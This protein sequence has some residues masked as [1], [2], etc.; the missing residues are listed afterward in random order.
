MKRPCRVPMI[1][2]P[3]AGRKKRFVAVG[4]GG[5]IPMFIDPIARDYAGD[6]ELV[7]LCDLSMVRMKYHQ[8]RL[9]RLYGCGQVR[10][11]RPEQFD[12]MLEELAP[13]SVIVCTTDALHHEYIIRSLESGCG[14]ICEKPLT[15]DAP[16][17][18]AIFD[19]VHRTGRNVRVTFNFRW[20]PG[21]TEV[22]RQL[23]DGVIG[24]V[25]HVHMEYLLDTRHGADY[26]RRWHSSKDQSGGLLV[27][28][29]TH[30]FD[31][32][33]WWLD[34]I[35]DSVYAAGGLVFYGRKN[36]LARGEEHLTRYDR[37]TGAPSQ[38]DPFR[39]D[40]TESESARALYYEAETETGYLR[41]KNVFRDGIDIEDSMSVIVKYRHGAILNYSLNAYCPWEGFRVAFTG[42]KGRIEYE[43]VHQPHIIRGQSDA[44]LA[45]EQH[46][47]APYRIRLLPLFG[48]AQVLEIPRATGAHGGG[49]TLLQQQIF[50]R[51][52]PA[53]TLNRNARHEQ[54]AASA[55][56]G[57]A[58]NLS[59]TSGLPVKIADLL[60]LAPGKTKL[61]ELL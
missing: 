57:I 10:L 59:M 9:E 56:I 6:C 15:T 58:A 44:Q 14:V 37:Y 31:L 19:A 34:G 38:G 48:P 50:A 25:K 35:P 32:V 8:S 29:A 52:P 39:L 23:R 60:P 3:P 41:D 61:Q 27:H 33:N 43:E 11:Y 54:G 2:F 20:S 13:D 55:L 47:D 53:D 1:N 26:F 24:D 12:A 4:A 36:A 21:V 42:D 16:K 46:G 49:D 40:L 18:R 22:R 30:H 5:R 17:C 45:A 51:K 7:G 28:K